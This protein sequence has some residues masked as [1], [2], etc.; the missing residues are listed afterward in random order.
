M[1]F[2]RTTDTPEPA[3][4]AAPWTGPQYEYTAIG[5]L[6]KDAV[7]K[8]NTLGA[9]GWH[10]VAANDSRIILMRERRPNAG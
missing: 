8:L 7:A 1:G 2:R 6:V 5:S 9:E 10:V 3:A 4:P